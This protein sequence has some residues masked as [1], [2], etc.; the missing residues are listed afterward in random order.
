MFR[1]QTVSPIQNIW[2]KNLDYLPSD[3]RENQSDDDSEAT[4]DG[5]DRFTNHQVHLSASRQGLCVPCMTSRGERGCG[6]GGGG[7]VSY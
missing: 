1:T 4:D 7:G 5:F 3:S 6:A 2:A